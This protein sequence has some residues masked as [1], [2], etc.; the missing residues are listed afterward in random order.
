MSLPPDEADR[1]RRTLRDLVALS[2]LP[3]AWQ[4]YDP[5]RLADSAAEMAVSVLSVDLG[6]L[7]LG[8]TAGASSEAVRRP[9]GPASPAE[10]RKVC[11]AL[12]P[13]LQHSFSPRGTIADP[14]GQGVLHLAAARFGS[15]PDEGVL[16]AGSRRADFPSEA[17][18]LLLSVAAN[19]VAIATYRI[20]AD[21]ERSTLIER[22]QLL[23]AVVE[24]TQDA[25][26]SKTLEGVITSWNRAAE[27]LF[28]YSAAEA[29]G[30]PVI[31]LIP[32]DRRHEEDLIL[33]QIRHGGTVD[34]YDTIRQRKDGTL[35]EISLT[36][37]PIIDREGRVVGA[38]KIARDITDR[39]RIEA[40][41]QAAWQRE[42]E[43]H[44]ETQLAEE[45]ERAARTAAER[46]SR[47]R[48]EFLATVSHELRNPL[49]SVLGWTELLRRAPEDEETRTQ[50]VEAIERG[51][52]A[53]TRLI[54][55]LLDMS[56][57][58]SGKL[59]LDVQTVDLA[60]LVQAAVET[61]QPGA[62]AKAIRIEQVIDP[63]AGPIKGDAS[64]LLQIFW[65]LLSNAVKFTPRGGKVQVHLERV[66]SHVEL[67]VSDTGV[68]IV[69]EFLP[70]V[71]DRFRQADSSTT[72]RFGGLGL[73]LS[74]V[75][76]LVELHGGRVWAR[77]AGE[78][79]GSTFSVHLPIA[80]VQQDPAGRE[81]PAAPRPV[82]EPWEDVALAGVRVL[83][84]DD[85]PDACE[86]LRRVLEERGAQVAVAT[87]ARA[88][89]AQIE[90]SEP[91]V[92]VSDIGMPEIDGYE[93]I[94]RVRARGSTLAAV[95]VTA[96]ARAED[97]I[98]A[99]RAG[100]NMHVAKPLEPKE[101]IA[102]VAALVSTESSGR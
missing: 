53:Q 89:L 70:H 43:A 56:R 45:R 12:L 86:V 42:R 92:L 29:L 98:R 68:G 75:K 100:F 38:S 13:W 21:H 96:F 20:R 97:R 52:R 91:D 80:I 50:A 11:E 65:N 73:G 94:R 7:R 19:Q 25:V 3:A 62:E 77:S 41:R 44:K 10:A 23:A 18:R 95:A 99:L 39:R 58:I 49:N 54:D 48:D 9:G 4:S 84:V 5:D 1:L 2:V 35:I 47:L 59:R 37:S 90:Q 24:S 30:R 6:Y 16:V 87:S 22:S 101:L 28:G 66:N 93:L 78:G 74:L 79:L 46:A 102:V 31:M 51:A 88:A 36:V 85:D 72:R 61:I 15:G 14:L 69:P 26:V 64:R 27:R 33:G 81:H 8:P 83:V 71:F 63:L 76:H 67:S 34:S 40:E 55:D 32:A 17:E 60:P 82:E 57:I